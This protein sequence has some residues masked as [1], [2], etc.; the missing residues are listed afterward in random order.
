MKTLSA[1]E[2]KNKLERNP[3]VHLINTLNPGNFRKEHIPNSLNVSS[4][5]IAKLL[6]E[7]DEEIILYCTDVNCMTSYYAYLH[8]EKSGYKISGDF[9]AVCANGMKKDFRWPRN[10]ES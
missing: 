2:V 10:S 5:D 1:I 8:L 3:N 7:K 4:V 9:R 6:F